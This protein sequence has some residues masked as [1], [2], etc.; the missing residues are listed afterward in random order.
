[1]NICTKRCRQSSISHFGQNKAGL[2]FFIL[3]CQIK[4]NLCLALHCITRIDFFRLFWSISL[5]QEKRR[6]NKK[7]DRNCHS[8]PQS[9]KSSRSYLWNFQ[10]RNPQYLIL[11]KFWRKARIYFL[12]ICCRI[13]IKLCLLAL[14]VLHAWTSSEFILRFAL[15]CILLSKYSLSTLHWAYYNNP[16]NWRC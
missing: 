1:M 4:I 5:R 6:G 10:S 15:P 11:A 16:E 9:C 8:K 13:R 3:C 14:C 7:F 12:I 2:D